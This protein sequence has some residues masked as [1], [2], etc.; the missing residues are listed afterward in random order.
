M[1]ILS[2]HFKN[3]NSL[4]GDWHIDFT[5]PAYAD[6]GIFAIT[7]PTG[8]GKTTILDAICLALY[9]ETP[10]LS[11]LSQSTNELMTRGASEC[12]AEVQFETT[13]GRYRVTWQQRRARKKADGQLQAPKHEVVNAA[14]GEP[15]ATKLSEVTKLIDEI[16][17]MDF[18]R[19]TRSMLL[20]QGRFAAFLQSNP[21]ERAPILEQITGTAIYS[22]I[23]IAVFDRNKQATETLQQLQAET[24]G[25]EILQPDQ[26][27][28]LQAD[29]ANNAT[30]TDDTKKQIEQLDTQIQWLQS[31]QQLTDQIRHEEQNQS[32]LDVE[33]LAFAPSRDRLER[34]ALASQLDLSYSELRGCRREMETANDEAA[35]IQQQLLQLQQAK[36]EAEDRVDVLTKTL[37]EK[38]EE[39]DAK[40]SLLGEVRKID[41]ELQQLRN[42]LTTYRKDLAADTAKRQRV[43][44]NLADHRTAL[45]NAEQQRSNLDAYLTLH[46]QDASLV[47]QFSGIEA[48]VCMWLSQSGDLLLKRKDRD[49]DQGRLAAAEKEF[50]KET[51]GLQGK[52]LAWDNAEA[53]WKQ[54]QE[55]LAKFLNG[56]LLRE[57]ESHREDLIEQKRLRSI[58]QSLAM[59]RAALKPGEA[60]PLCGAT[61]HPYAVGELPLPDA[62][63]NEIRGLE[64]FIAQAK[65]LEE[66]NLR[67]EKALETAQNEHRL[68]T[69]Q[70]DGV[71]SRV[72][73]LSEQVKQRNSDLQSTEEK[74][75]NL[76]C[77]LLQRLSPYGFEE[78]P[79][80]QD[81]DLLDAL[82]KRRDR[83]QE[84]HALRQKIESQ[85]A[86]IQADVLRDQATDSE[87]EQSIAKRT[88]DLQA[89]EQAVEDTQ[90]V[91]RER[92]GDL[93]PDTES[94]RW[95]QEIDE[96][97]RSTAAAN[98]KWQAAH[99]DW[100]TAN[101]SLSIFLSRA[102]LAKDQLAI[103]EPAL[104]AEFQRLGFA[105]EKD[106]QEAKLADDLRRELHQKQNEL[107]KRQHAIAAALTKTRA[108]LQQETDRK[109][110]DRSFEEL[111]STKKGLEEKRDTSL[112]HGGELQAQLQRHQDN[113]ARVTKNAAQ[114]EMQRVE[115][116]RW[117]QLNHLIG[118]ADGKKYRNFV[119]SLTFERLVHFANLQLANMYDRYLL[120]PD[121]ETPLNLNVIDTYQAGEVRSTKNLSGGETFIV[122]L[123]LALGLS[124]LASHKVRVDSLFLDEGFGTLDEDALDIALDTLSSLHQEGK[125]IG[126]I[127]HIPALKERISTKIQ[128]SPQGAGR[129]ILSGP[130]CSRTP[131]S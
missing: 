58:I 87:L 63:E 29:L 9:G 48:D 97:E 80:E 26:L 131:T 6:S 39:R 7:G 126:V 116:E 34:D 1:K 13:R 47:E 62:L 42:E 37:A 76:R 67:L 24:E 41:N 31:L 129:S 40:Q 73:A 17:G 120:V 15:L 33:V 107:E 114:I 44:A 83:W 98:K 46:A 3:L 49:A 86:Q 99:T 70:L 106:F 84:N 43:T 14:T 57:Y 74:L 72:E 71:K 32:R 56:K 55:S 23:S 27:A 127:S 79:A 115:C 88:I 108:T 54:G 20:A 111:Q 66:T 10:R 123:A 119:Q 28:Q 95:Q 93:D 53:A 65:S 8:A 50:T 125:L 81:T 124:R 100:T 122:S 94:A 90:R 96:L 91:R 101:T 12:S 59:H 118:S 105:D 112:R 16:T 61:E 64:Q 21:N 85:M 36:Q 128:V 110:T 102:S 60:C 130:G 104:H 68:A 89:K 22:N 35:R 121:P 5:H 75:T 38:K 103:L 78:L 77:G 109:L 113:E 82:K 69:V 51:E 19:F 4:A 30:K 11:S 2:V 18:D 45:A 52:L 25:I 92:F 117:S